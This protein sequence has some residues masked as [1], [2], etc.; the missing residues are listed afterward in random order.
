MIRGQ[1]SEAGLIKAGVPQGS[2]LGPLLFLIYIN[3]LPNGIKS[4][5]KLFADD[6][7]IYIDFDNPDQAAE[8]L[9]GDLLYLKTWA[10]QWLV[11]FSPAKT[12]SMTLAFKKQNNPPQL[13]FNDVNLDD[14]TD[15]KHLGI[16][17]SSNLNWS[18][19][20]KT[21]LSGVS[22]MADV[23]KRLKYQV[24]RK[25]LETIYF[26]YIR[27]KLEYGCHI[28]ANCSDR[29]ALLLEKFQLDIARTVSG[30][31]IGTSTAAIYDEL[32]WQTL[33]SRRESLKLKSLSKIVTNTAPPYLCELLPRTVGHRRTLRNSNNLIKFKCRTETF[34]S[35][36]VPSAVTLWNN[37][38][39]VNR[40]SSYIQTL[41]KTNAYKLFYWGKRETSVK[42]AQLRMRCSKL[43][44]HLFNLHVVDSSS[45]NC[46]HL[47]EDTNHYLLHCPLYTLERNILFNNL[48]L[49]G[50]DIITSKTMLN[51]LSSF[52]YDNNVKIFEFVFIFIEKSNRL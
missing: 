49:L 44:A 8:S 42:H 36:F 2:V 46:G 17:L 50:C 11:K 27:P 12:K 47:V 40:T 22:A 34:R 29:D 31:R 33:K 7:T 5:I 25:T 15:H 32:G 28:W 6:A 30:A 19:H 39:V 4:N 26:S 51:G 37:L 10:D 24:D 38:D 9:N 45:C 18:L 35:S 16:T 48:N 52:N 43:N 3:D 13:V 1:S 41:F 14:V 23:L 20:I 21:I